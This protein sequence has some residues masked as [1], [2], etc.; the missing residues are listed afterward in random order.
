MKKEV[1]QNHHVICFV[2]DHVRKRK[3]KSPRTSGEEKRV[4][5]AHKNNVGPS[6]PSSQ[7][8]CNSNFLCNPAL[9]EIWTNCVLPVDTLSV[10]LKEE[11]FTALTYAL[12]KIW[13]NCIL[14]VDT[15][16]VQSKEETFTALTH[17]LLEIW[18]NCILPVDAWSV[19]SKEETFTALAAHQLHYAVTSRACAS[20]CSS[21]NPI[22]TPCP[23]H[24]QPFS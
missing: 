3:K 23:Y 7:P 21:S 20:W 18:T 6:S 19:Q 8:I 11:T 9:P 5:F 22:T 17:A 2:M 24:A 4:E 12:L 15:W 16:S 14:P 13:T 1:A 10:Q